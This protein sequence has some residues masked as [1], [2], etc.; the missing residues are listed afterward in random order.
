MKIESEKYG[1]IHGFAI[2]EDCDWTDGIKTVEIN[3]MQKLRARVYK[4][5]RR[6]GH[7]VNL[8][9][10]TSTRYFPKQKE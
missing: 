8:E 10:G 9:T 4:H 6:F 1:I 5:I 7:K 2:C 3:R